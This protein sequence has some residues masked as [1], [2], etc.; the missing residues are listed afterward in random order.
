MSRIA[1]ELLSKLRAGEEVRANLISLRAE[2][3]KNEKERSIVLAT[4]RDEGNV[5]IDLLQHEDAKARKNA[6]LI[7]GKVMTVPAGR[8]LPKFIWKVG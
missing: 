8:V 5:L 6:A 4:L 7:L 3:K 2:L 1:E